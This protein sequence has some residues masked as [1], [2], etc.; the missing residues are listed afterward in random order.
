MYLR[1]PMYVIRWHHKDLLNDQI[2][3]YSTFSLLDQ[4]L[5][6]LHFLHD[7]DVNMYPFW[8]V[9][10][11][12]NFYLQFLSIFFSQYLCAHCLLCDI[13]HST[14]V[15]SNF[16]EEI[17]LH[18]SW[19]THVYFFRLT[20]VQQIV[21]LLNFL[22]ISMINLTSL[23]RLWVQTQLNLLVNCPNFCLPAN[24]CEIEVA[25]RYS[26]VYWYHFEAH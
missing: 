12:V 17:V 5:D 3:Q 6:N 25:K 1:T 16:S 13:W 22:S 24:R 8:Y 19:W 2:W 21:N 4:Q 7:S 18:L 20:Y 23:R 9:F 26:S 15:N 11:P 10:M 14:F